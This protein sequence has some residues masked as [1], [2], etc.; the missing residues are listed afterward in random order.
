MIGVLARIRPLPLL[1]LAAVWIM[2]WG[3]VS[4]FLVVSGLIVSAVVLVAFPLPNVAPNIRV[5]PWALLKLIGWFLRELTV[6]SVTVSWAAVRPSGISA[7][8]IVRVRLNEQ[9]DLVRTVIA[10]MIT[11]VPGTMVIE[12][13]PITSMVTVHVLGA[14]SHEEMASGVDGL[15][16]LERRVQAALGGRQEHDTLGRPMNKREVGL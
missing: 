8:G 4:V 3:H 10:A 9:D 2:L 5:R 12:M 14:H 6:A 1:G 7:G 13:N 11:L 15:L 16:E